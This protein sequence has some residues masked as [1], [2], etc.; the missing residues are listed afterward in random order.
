M[1]RLDVVILL[2]FSSLC[3][4]C[5]NEVSAVSRTVSGE[6]VAEDASIA[7]PVP[8]PDQGL[9]KVPDVGRGPMQ[10]DAQLN[11]SEKDSGSNS[12]SER[13]DCH[14]D[15]RMIE[16]SYQEKLRL[17]SHR[18]CE[19]DGECVVLPNATQCSD[20][21]CLDETAAVNTEHA[22]KLKAA[23]Y[24]ADL[25]VC[26]AL[27]QLCAQTVLTKRT[28][29]FCVPSRA[30]AICEAGVCVSTSSR[31]RR[32]RRGS[33]RSRLRIA[34]TEVSDE[35]FT[36]AVRQSLYRGRNAAFFQCE[37]GTHRKVGE[38]IFEFVVSPK[39][40]LGSLRIAASTLPQRMTRCLRTWLKGHAYPS[41]K[42][43]AVRVRQTV[44][45]R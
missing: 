10:P 23:Q 7:Q 41:P 15:R 18:V 33:R 20:T 32:S 12:E 14:A 11:E 26:H 43:Q 16:E 9:V 19:T 6:F 40:A 45:Y 35:S 17:P 25:Q 13:S 42:A 28:S 38:A 22:K 36:L 44:R 30:R 3:F 4:A 24:E 37:E 2:L 39:G 1:M 31:Q 29:A 8:A 34:T 21:L 5:R 27:N